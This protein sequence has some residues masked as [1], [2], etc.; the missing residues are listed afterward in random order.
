MLPALVLAEWWIRASRSAIPGA[1]GRLRAIVSAPA[2]T[3]AVTAETLPVMVANALPPSAIARRTSINCTLADFTAASAPSINEATEKASMM[4]SASSAFTFV[5]PLMAGKIDSCTFG[6]TKV[7]ITE[8]P[9]ACVPASIAAPTAATS[10][11]TSTM[12]LPEQIVRARTSS[13][14]AA[15][16]I[17]SATC[18]PPAMLPSSIN[19]IEFLAI[20]YVCI[21]MCLPVT[22]ATVPFTLE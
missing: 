4:P 18:M 7:S 14:S 9:P 12:Y 19:P 5:M 20:G 10:P 1:A 2:S 21:S 15:F 17:A 11:R 16:N 8:K 22:S 6:I 13:T 3:A